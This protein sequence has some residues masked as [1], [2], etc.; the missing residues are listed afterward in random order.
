MA[1]PRRAIPQVTV[2]ATVWAVWLAM[3]A[4]ALLLIAHYGSNVPSWDDW[5]MVPTLTH[6]QPVTLDWLWSQHNEHRVPLPRLIYLAFTRP[7]KGDLRVMMYVDVLAMAALAVACILTARRLRGRTALADAIFP[8]LLL[9]LGQAVNLLW[10]WQLQFFASAMLA[11]GALL[12][13]SRAGTG[14]DARRAGIIAGSCALLLTLCGANGLGMVPALALWPLALALLPPE[15]TGAPGAKG[16]RLLVALAVG[17]LVLTVL[18]FVGWQRV[19]WHP[20]SGGPLKTLTTSVQFLTVG[21]GPVAQKAWPW[22]GLG[23]VMFVVASALRLF[24]VYRSN[25]LERA[26][27]GGLLL[28]L[29]AIASLALGLGLGRNGFETR[30]V[31]L[32]LPA[33]C[34]G[35]LVWCA[36]PSTS[37]G[38]R[39]CG[40]AAT[41]VFLLVLPA[42]TRIGLTYAK[43]LRAHLQGFEYDLAAGTPLHELVRRYD[44]YLHPHQ[45][46]PLEYL[47]ML[48]R[49]GIGRFTALRDDP[50]VQAMPLTLAPARV[51]HVVWHDS[52]GRVLAKYPYVDFSLPSD[53]FV[54]GIRLKFRNHGDDGSLPFVGVQWKRKEARDFPD[55]AFKKYSPTGDRA[56]WERGTWTRLHDA[57]TTMTV[58]ISDTI[59]QIRIMP[60][61]VPGVFRITELVL[62]VPAEQR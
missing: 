26:R 2:T 10:A 53:R 17:A 16:S 56:N 54:G 60:N 55:S 32:A 23:V 7:L 14:M 20:R 42:N 33:W 24:Q 13:I 39:A 34:W 59:G 12:A 37:V 46:I 51:S 40:I 35:Y 44:P 28:F 3:L 58:W 25:P 41:I 5:D 22:L 50:P 15:W 43:D 36:Y 49:A 45:D 47:P 8:L 38:S 1:T 11:L 30:Y 31:T 4:A 18:Y 6:T 19:P 52:T 27:A 9:D 62:L 29:G 61:L 57:E 21:L 48:R